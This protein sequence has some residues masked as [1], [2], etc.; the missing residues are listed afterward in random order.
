[1]TGGG[2]LS[3]SASKTDDC[4][5]SHQPV[6]AVAAHMPTS[7]VGL[8]YFQETPPTELFRECSDFV[9]LVTNPAQMPNVLHGAVNTAVDRRGVAVLVMP[10]EV[11][12]ADARNAHGAFQMSAPR[13]ARC[14]R[15]S[16]PSGIV[17][18]SRR[19]GSTTFHA[20][21]GLDDLAKPP[22]DDRPV[23]PQYLTSI[24]T[25][26]QPPTRSSLRTSARRALP[27]DERQTTSPRLPLPRLDG[28]RPAPRPSALRLRFRGDRSSPCRGTVASAC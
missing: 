14:C 11:A 25:A 28:Q 26:S 8:G 15:G 1:M 4:R 22:P 20:R 27:D 16:R 13:F 18:S 3:T 21:Q 17:P 7:E 6:L 2:S 19:H 12:L 10:G 5:R 24:I 23:H 9:E